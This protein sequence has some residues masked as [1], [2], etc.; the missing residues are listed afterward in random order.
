M[1]FIFIVLVDLV[2]IWVMRSLEKNESIFI[3]IILMLNDVNDIFILD[4][5]LMIY[6][7]LIICLY[8]CMNND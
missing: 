4:K 2:C 3:I 5:Y 1:V 8:L 6:I 7:L